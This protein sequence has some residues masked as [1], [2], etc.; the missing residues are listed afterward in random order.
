MAHN[1]VSEIIKNHLIYFFVFSLTILFIFT[2]LINQS[3]AGNLETKISKTVMADLIPAD[4][5]SRQDEELIEEAAIPA[6][7]MAADKK[8]DADDAYA[9][10]KQDSLIIMEDSADELALV[11]NDTGDTLLKPRFIGA[12]TAGGNIITPARS[13][14]TY[15][16]VQNGDTVSTIARRF[17]LTINTVLW[18]NNL[19]AF[20]LIRPGDS[21]TILPTSGILYTVKTGDVISKIAARYGIDADKILSA[22]NISDSLKIG[23]KIILP[24]ASKLSEQTSGTR[25]ATQSGLSVIRNLIKTPTVKAGTG[26]M[27]WPTS[28]YRITQYFSWRHNGVDIGNKTGTPIYAAEAG[29]VE[30]ARGGYNGGYGNTIVINHGGGLKTRYGH[31]SKFFVKVGDEVEKGENIAAMGST[32]RST[33]SHLHFEVLINGTRY[34]PLNYIK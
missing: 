31:I 2:N 7:M 27:A 32:G 25:A 30:I 23:Q 20:S 6:N 22:N 3:Q 24:G 11:F 29:I 18:A 9:L 1:A 15:Y 19:S 12:S 33:G 34:N 13:E 17:G 5:G 26:K 28:G 8:K 16:T 14:I 4:L 10:N 21:L